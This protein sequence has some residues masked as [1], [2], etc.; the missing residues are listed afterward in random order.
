MADKEFKVIYLYCYSG[1]DNFENELNSLFDDGYEPYMVAGDKFI[2]RRKKR[3]SHYY[4][5]RIRLDY[6][7][8]R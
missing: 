7:P 6:T 2:L 4:N 1:P 8:D 3:E 5:N